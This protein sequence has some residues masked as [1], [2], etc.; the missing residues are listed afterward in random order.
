MLEPSSNTSAAAAID[1]AYSEAQ[2][3]WDVGDLLR[4][5]LAD[6][7]FDPES[8]LVRELVHAVS[9]FLRLNHGDPK[10]GCR[11][12]PVTE[13]AGPC[14]P[15]RISEATDETVALWRNM[16]D[17]VTNQAAKARFH[18]LLF[19]RG[20]GNRR[21]HALAAAAA[22]LAAADMQA[23][24]TLDVTAELVRAW[25]LVRSVGAAELEQLSLGAMLAR[26]TSGLHAS[27]A[28][29]PGCV[30]PLLSVLATPPRRSTS[31]TETRFASGADPATV[32]SLLDEAWLVYRDGFHTAQI[33]DLMR[34]HAHG[35]QAAVDA[36]GRREIETYLTEADAASGMIKQGI[37]EKAVALSRDLGFTDLRAQATAKLQAIPVASLGLRPISSTLTVSPEQVERALAS[38][39]A[40]PEWQDGL[41]VFLAASCPTGELSAIKAQAIELSKVAVFRYMTATVR[42]NADGLPVSTASSPEERDGAFLAECAGVHAQL[43]GQALARGLS[44]MKSEY[45]I[46]SEAELLVVL[47]GN[48][49]WDQRLAASLAKA[50]VHFWNE[51]YESCLAVAITKIEASA[52]ALLREL[53]EPIFRTQLGQ[54]PGDYPS[55]HKL[56]ARLEELALDESWAYFLRW[57]LVSSNGPNLRNDFAHGLVGNVGPVYAALVL[58]AATMLS[59]LVPPQVDGRDP[60][61]AN[62]RDELLSRLAEPIPE[63]ASTVEGGAHADPFLGRRWY[64]TASNRLDVRPLI[65]AL[66]SR[67]VEPYVLSDVV[68]SGTPIVRKSQAAIVSADVVMAVLE[69]GIALQGALL[70]AGIAAGLGKPTVIVADL[71]D[72]AQFERPG[73]II[74]RARPDDTALI[75]RAL[76]QALGQLLKADVPAAQ[77][78]KPIGQLTDE[79]IARLF[80]SAPIDEYFAAEVLADAIDASGASAAEGFQH[81]E[82]RFDIGVWSDDLAE[83]GLNPLIVELKSSAQTGAAQQTLHYLRTNPNLRAAL[84]VSIEP[85][86]VSLAPEQVP[87]P[88][89]VI[90]LQ[91]LLEQMRTL[92]FAEVVRRLRNRSVHGRPA[93]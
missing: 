62:D 72:A 16:A 1:A 81:G 17:L 10:A 86:P 34:V 82:N 28:S 27:P 54:D 67:G 41:R 49:S 13:T 47:S 50:F 42:V 12:V 85:D 35:D 68:E 22:Y 64:V 71:A 3:W 45:G 37:L 24:L 53:S 69:P 77:R 65:A 73:T 83:V 9:Y 43:N 19:E 30:L 26:V 56:L 89:L 44:R 25:D 36:I 8:L 91:E 29:P 84:L 31:T 23:D 70:D 87:F 14:W 6:A 75:N 61:A 63:T 33:A 66:K 20:H 79:L 55:L 58:K 32:A 78:E 40:S 51:D 39:T 11:L 74:I 90:T 4:A 92:S 2:R 21:D 93:L 38:F 59:T 7:E 88:V 18:D 60:T 15:P 48:G 46:P 80:R 76:D 5:R 57:L 52:R